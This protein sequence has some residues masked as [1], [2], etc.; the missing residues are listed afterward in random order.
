MNN[1]LDNILNEYETNTYQRNLG[2]GERILHYI[3]NKSSQKTLPRT[4]HILLLRKENREK[5]SI[6]F[7]LNVQLK[8]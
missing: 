8:I 2:I 6:S 4:N 5:Q 7:P 3:Q 1:I